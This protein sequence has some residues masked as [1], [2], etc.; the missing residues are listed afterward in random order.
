MKT[1]EKIA[2]AQPD[3]TAA[4][5]YIMVKRA[6][7]CAG[8]ISFDPDHPGVSRFVATTAGG[9]PAGL[10]TGTGASFRV[11]TPGTTDWCAHWQAAAEAV[12]GPGVTVELA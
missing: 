11:E 9:R 10:I 3:S 8:T 4:G 2:G 6:G 12:F 1:P 7:A 5:A